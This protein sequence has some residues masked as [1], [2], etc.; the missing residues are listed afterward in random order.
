MH[1]V[2]LETDFHKELP[3]KH[4]VEIGISLNMSC[5]CLQNLMASF[6]FFW[7]QGDEFLLVTVKTIQISP[8]AAF[9]SPNHSPV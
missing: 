4:P 7:R 5:I 3:G 1:V 6:T 8:K 2:A 9:F